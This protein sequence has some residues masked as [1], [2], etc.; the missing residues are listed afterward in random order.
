MANNN[1]FIGQKKHQTQYTAGYFDSGAFQ[2]CLNNYTQV[3]QVTNLGVL[4]QMLGFQ[5][6][7]NEIEILFFSLFM[8]HPATLFFSLYCCKCDTKHE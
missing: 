8:T 2:V 7:Q 4:L 3:S 5:S 1:G 6:L